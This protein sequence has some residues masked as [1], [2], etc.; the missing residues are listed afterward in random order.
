MASLTGPLTML[1]LEDVVEDEDDLCN[2]S[3]DDALEVIRGPKPG[4]S[5]DGIRTEP[6]ALCSRL[7]WVGADL[8]PKL[9]ADGGLVR[10][11]TEVARTG[12]GGPLGIDGCGVFDGVCRPCRPRRSAWANGL[13][14]LCL[15]LEE[16][17]VW[18]DAEVV[19]MAV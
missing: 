14:A 9:V 5:V 16:W 8:L 17:V 18:P 13:T 7:L 19:G 10:A 12:R 15:P 6:E 2:F 4:G 3:L 1:A 11:G